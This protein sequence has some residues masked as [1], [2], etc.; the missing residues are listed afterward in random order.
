MNPFL[1][2][3]VVI[4]AL[5]AAGPAAAKLRV[6][7]CEPEWG[8][9]ARTLGEEQVEVYTATTARQ[10]PH[11]VQARPSL[12]SR[13]RRADLVVC[14]GAEL[15]IGWLP[16]LLRQGNNPRVQPGQPGYLAAAEHVRLLG[17]PT[18]VDRS[19]GDIHPYGN[20]H[21]QTDPHN[22]ARVAAVLTDRLVQLDPAHET[23]YRQRYRH[24]ANRW[25]QAMARWELEAAPLR[26]G[27]V[28]THHEGWVYLTHWLG[29]TVVGHL[30]PKPG[31]PPSGAHLARLLQTLK[32][33]PAKMVIRAAYQDPR[34][35]RWLASHGN[36]VTVTLPFT[37]GGTPGAKDLFGLYED[38]VQRL[39]RAGR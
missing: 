9:L 14:T 35:S 37:V 31:V 34:P 36:T 12:I 7:A 24:F 4:L 33:R 2:W 3:L 26:G 10:D 13:M 17:I 20:P 23:G 1:R 5:S 38:T 21:I 30:E 19:E 22:I 25:Q 15:E 16:V 39:L 29:L 27:A 6:F 8:A 18:R 28:V 32:T 11:H